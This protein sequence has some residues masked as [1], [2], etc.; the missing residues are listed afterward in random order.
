MLFMNIVYPLHDDKFTY[1]TIT[2]LP[3][4]FLLTAIKD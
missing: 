1:N 4:A 2:C 3:I